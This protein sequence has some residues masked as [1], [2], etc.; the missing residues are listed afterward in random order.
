MDTHIGRKFRYLFMD[1]EMCRRSGTFSWVPIYAG[2]LG[3]YSWMLGFV[4][5]QIPIHGYPDMQEIEV[6]IHGYPDTQEVLVSV[7]GYPDVQEVHEY[8]D[9]QEVE[10]LFMDAQMC[11]R[12]GTYSWIS[13]HAEG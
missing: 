4:E 9:M 7:H 11:R 5:C 1:A 10:V 2:S 13:R 8:P 3:T 6:P 12:S